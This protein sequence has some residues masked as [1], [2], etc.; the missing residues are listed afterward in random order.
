MAAKTTAC[1]ILSACQP[2]GIKYQ[3]NQVVEFPAAMVSALKDQGVID[4]S[5]G[6]VDYCLKELGV[7]A[8]VHAAADDA[9]QA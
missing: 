5:K 2:D 7:T 4:P 3:P 1:R 9:D 6:A 8:V